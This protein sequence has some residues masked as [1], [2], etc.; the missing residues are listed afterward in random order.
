MDRGVTHPFEGAKEAG[1]CGD[2][3]YFGIIFRALANQI[4]NDVK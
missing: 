3:Y 2:K 1:V 4:D